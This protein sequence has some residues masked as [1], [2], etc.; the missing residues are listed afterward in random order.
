VPLHPHLV[1]QGFLEFV[2][3]RGEAPLFFRPRSNRKTDAKQTKTLKSPAAQVRQRLADW[4]REIGVDDEHLSPNHAWRHTFKLIG[5]RA[6]ISDAL[7]DYICGHAPA[8]EGRRYGAPDLKDLARA[9]ERFP[10]YELD[11]NDET[12]ASG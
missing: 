8:T 10:R 3:G 2:N 11:P 4:V 5:S 9:I 6:E 7:L 12:I 1:E